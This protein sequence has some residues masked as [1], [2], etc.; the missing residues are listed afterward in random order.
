LKLPAS[1]LILPQPALSNTTGKVIKS[2]STTRASSRGKRGEKIEEEEVVEEEEEE[3]KKGTKK[4]RRGSIRQETVVELEP[5]REPEPELITKKVGGRKRAAQPVTVE[6]D[7]V[8]NATVVS[9]ET[10]QDFS[11]MKVVE[12]KAELV[13]R[14]L[15]TD[16]LKAVLLERLQQ[17]L[18]VHPLKKR[19]V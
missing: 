8:V 14:G 5:E 19:R 4:K 13:K 18:I 15:P 12:L 9:S 2:K 17:S 3:E 16:G 10:V 1:T 11:T 6:E 7:D